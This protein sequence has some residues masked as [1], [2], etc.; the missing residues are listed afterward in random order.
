MRVLFTYLPMPDKPNVK[1]K[2]F[3]LDT[4]SS[5]QAQ[6]AA[7]GL[8]VPVGLFAVWIF[9]GFD[10]L[11]GK[12]LDNIYIQTAQDLEAQYR[13]MG[14]ESSDIDKCVKAGTVA[15]AWLNAQDQVEYQNWKRIEGAHCTDAG[16]PQ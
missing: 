10:W 4:G 16:V 6:L 2:S 13:L 15:A 5:A 12:Q 7:L 11:T 3:Q 1:V 9:G 14:S 8:L